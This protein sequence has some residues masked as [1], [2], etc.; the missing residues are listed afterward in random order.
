VNE[1]IFDEDAAAE[2][3]LERYGTRVACRGAP[4]FLRLKWK[5]DGTVEASEH[6]DGGGFLGVTLASTWA[7]AAVVA[8]GRAHMTDPSSEPPAALIPGLA[9]GLTLACVVSRRDRVGWRMRLPDGSLFQP[10]PEAGFMLDMLRRALQMATPAPPAST[11]VLLLAGWVGAICA[12][13]RGGALSRLD[14]GE[15]LRLHPAL[16]DG[17]PLDPARAEAAIRTPR[18]DGEWETMRLL[19]A[20]GLGGPGLPDP[21]VARWMDE[22]MFARWALSS[23]PAVSE[24]VDETRPFLEPPAFRRLAHLARRVDDRTPV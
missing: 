2:D 1:V 13:G 5:P 14:W 23:L 10:V 21:E 22:G 3:L 19:V 17:D 15:A 24:L 7:A 4:A 11:A 9:G 12:T 6:R 8:T 18:S 20:A 16:A